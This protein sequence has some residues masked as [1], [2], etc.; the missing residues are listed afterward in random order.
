MALEINNQY[1]FFKNVNLD[2]DGNLCVSVLGTASANRIESPDG[3]TYIEAHDGW[4]EQV[5]DGDVTIDTGLQLELTAGTNLILKA[6]GIATFANNGETA[7]VQITASEKLNL[8]AEYGIV[9]KDYTTFYGGDDGAF[10]FTTPRLYLGNADP[11]EDDYSWAIGSGGGAQI[12]YDAT[13][14]NFNNGTGNILVSANN[15]LTLNSATNLS[16]VLISSDI[17]ITTVGD[18][19]LGP[20][21]A[22]YIYPQ[23]LQTFASDA[24]AGIGG[25]PQG[26][27]YLRTTGELAVKL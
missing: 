7:Y 18:I 17:E 5:T 12:Y 23:A 6:P 13:D 11:G 10:N 21:S 24:A 16:N 4:L 3:N 15:D 20:G 8:R 14:A 2:D 1:D 26:A 25:V 9:I 27:M 19:I 22:S